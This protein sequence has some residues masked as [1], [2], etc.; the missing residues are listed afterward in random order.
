MDEAR[1]RRA[2]AAG[3]ALL[4]ARARAGHSAQQLRNILTAKGYAN[5][6]AVRTIQRHEAGDMLPWRVTWAMYSDVY[7]ELEGKL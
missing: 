1:K 6:P 7:P 5:P 4:R 2:K 3:R